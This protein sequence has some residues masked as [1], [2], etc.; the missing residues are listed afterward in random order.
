MPAETR[1]AAG[2]AAANCVALTNVVARAVPP[3]LTTEAARKFVPLTVSVKAAPPTAARV[4]EIVLIAGVGLDPLDGGDCRAASAPDKKHQAH[5]PQ[6][7]EP[8]HQRHSC[9]HDAPLQ[10]PTQ[11]LTRTSLQHNTI[12]RVHP[13]GELVRP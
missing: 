3:K 11:I 5:D 12:P 9:L 4:G 7:H 8:S 10:W 2:I 6:D 1:P 13:A